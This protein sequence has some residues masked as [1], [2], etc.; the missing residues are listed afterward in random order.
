MRVVENLPNIPCEVPRDDGENA[1][2]FKKMGYVI[3]I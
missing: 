3:S 2:R 1:W